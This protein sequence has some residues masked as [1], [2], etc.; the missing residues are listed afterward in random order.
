MLSLDSKKWAGFRIGDLFKIVSGRCSNAS[1]LEHDDKGVPYVGATNRNN[2]VLDF[3][4]P[5]E[6][7][8]MKGNCIAFIKQGEGSVGYAVYK[9]EDF[10][11]ATSIA[12]GYAPFVN[13]YTGLFIIT[14]ANQVRGR[15]SYNY[16]RSEARLKR[17]IIQLPVNDN[18]EPDWEFMEAF[19]RELE[20]KL[21]REY[22]AY[23]QAKLRNT[24]QKLL[25]I[26]GVKW[27]KFAIGDL[28]EVSLP[29]GDL[30]AD[31]C[32]DGDI[33][34]LS[35]GFHNN[36]ICKFIKCNDEKAKLYYGNVISVDMFG[37]AFF[38]GYKF[39]AVSHGRVNI[40]KPRSE[41]NKYH[42]LFIITAINYSIKGKFSYNQM[43]S[44]KR[45]KR[46]IL[47][48]P[49]DDSGRPDWPFMDAYMRAIEQK[50]LRDYLSYLT[51]KTQNSNSS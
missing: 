49:V 12:V 50:K 40:L 32:E 25:S 42:M 6:G 36:G 16:P 23:L 31:N 14:S 27:G 51:A 8:V 24:P 44:S 7:L 33:P 26:E 43:C 35:A 28:F 41:L 34:L 2:G 19:M 5:V 4:K 37:K 20:Q 29:S 22:Q 39:C 15:Y 18:G 45:V 10:I 48:L 46:L 3:V 13:K 11:A 1:N 47:Q 30:Q 9:Q 38:H 21:L 17:E